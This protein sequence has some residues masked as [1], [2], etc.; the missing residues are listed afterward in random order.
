LIRIIL[1]YIYLLLQ[2]KLA[3]IIFAVIFIF[4]L[5]IYNKS[6]LTKSFEISFSKILIIKGL[7]YFIRF[8]RFYP[9]DIYFEFL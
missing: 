5:S 4:K 3:K 9:P 7:V 1:S 6:G 8:F 2:N